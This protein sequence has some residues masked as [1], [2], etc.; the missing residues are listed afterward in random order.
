MWSVLRRVFVALPCTEV[1]NVATLGTFFVL[2]YYSV[3]IQWLH[4]TRVEAYLLNKPDA[5]L[6]IGFSHNTV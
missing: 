4:S 3:T 6:L 1:G 2:N 5:F